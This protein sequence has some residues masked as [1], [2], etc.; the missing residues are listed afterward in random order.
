MIRILHAADLHLDSPF[1]G[2]PA[3][4]TAIRRREQR[5]LLRTLPRLRSES[6]AQL[7]LL[8]GDVFDR[9]VAFAETEEALASAIA[10]CAVPVVISPG[11]HDYYA[12]GG[13]WDRMRLPENAYIF[14]RAELDF[15]DLPELDARVYGAAFTDR[16][17]PPLLR[18]F[19]APRDEGI[20]NIMCV[21]GEVGVQASRYNAIYEADI[22]ESG[23]DYVALGHI[24]AY[25]GARTA[26]R[27]PY[28]WPGCP[29]GRG[30][31]ECGEKGMIIADIGGGTPKITFVP[32][33]LRRYETLTFDLGA[34][35]AVELPPDAERNC[36]KIVLTGEV[37]SPPDIAALRRSLE[38]QCFAL[39]LRDE[40]RLRRDV[41]ERAG[42]DTLR[43]NFLRILKER[44]ESAENDAQREL[45]DRAARWGL[46]ALERREEAEEL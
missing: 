9:G 17:C 1:E 39:R 24:H 18:G 28:A 43:G 11:N 38:G 41:W 13:R 14:K 12:L 7:V 15:I 21:H 23:M 29:E 20:L 34:G 26:G 22:G 8:A 35:A 4:K 33:C 45:I 27:V 37:A 10:E 40:T 25:S 19:H 30:Y 2:L 5:E 3:E 44:L 32:T 42:E 36:Y 16:Y 46:A 31:D 6:G